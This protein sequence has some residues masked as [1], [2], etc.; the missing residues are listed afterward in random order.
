MSSPLFPNDPQF[1]F[2]TERA[3]GH[4]AYGGADSG[5]VLA[6]V[7]GITESDYESWYAGW[8]TAAERLLDAARAAEAAGH[9][10]TARD[11][12][13]RASNYFRAAEF[14][15]HGNPDDPRIDQ[16]YGNGV[17][18]FRSA[19]AVLGT[20]E[21]VQIPYD[22]VELS[23]YFY[24]SALPG[25]RPTLIMHNGFD[26]PVEELYFYGAAAAQER[27]FHVLA[28]DGPGQPSAR[29]RYGLTFRPDWEHVVTP[30]L[31]WLLTQTDRHV[32]P[33][34]IGLLGISM[35]GYL[36]PRAAAF[37]HRLAACIAVDG[38]YDLGLLSIQNSPYDRPKT[39]ELLRAKSSP[40]FDASIDAAMKSSPVARWAM[41]QGVYAMGVDTPREFLASYLDYSLA[42]GIAEQITCPTLVC[43]AENDV[44]YQGQAELLLAHLTCPATFFSF[45]AAEGAGAH[46]HSGAQRYA[47][48]RILDWLDDTLKPA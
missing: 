28:F 15:L 47:F 44:F 46:C 35:G 39:E 8:N 26:G 5:E 31:D 11:D 42:N 40:E 43:K 10:V 37:E 16:C 7:E 38:A 45:T 34:R 30:V 32:D 33:S 41:V 12:H 21:P 19:M 1:W 24:R 17:A 27:G 18:A 2:E 14:F 25:D 4:A 3:L 48:G 9:A 6:I 29:R 22:G 20:V 13:L 23:G 36:A